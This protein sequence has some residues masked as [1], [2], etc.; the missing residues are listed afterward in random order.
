M[1]GLSEFSVLTVFSFLT[2]QP[3]LSK[4]H[5]WVNIL[6][7]YVIFFTAVALTIMLWL[8]VSHVGSM[9]YIPLDVSV[10]VFLTIGGV[11]ASFFVLLLWVAHTVDQLERF[12]RSALNARH[13]NHHMDNKPKLLLN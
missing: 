8:F 9:V 2:T 1:D 6:K 4:E 12:I 5:T 7:F 3:S 10:A 11:I 13:T